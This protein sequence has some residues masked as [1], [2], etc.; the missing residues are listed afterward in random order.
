MNDFHLDLSD[1]TLI[2]NQI[3]SPMVASATVEECLAKATHPIIDVRSPGEF[4]EGH[5]PGAVNVPLYNDVE[6]KK[7]GTLYRHDGSEVATELGYSIAAEKFDSLVAK[8][9]QVLTSGRFS[10]DSNGEFVVHCWRGGLRSRGVAWLCK[11]NGLL[12]LVMEG[13]YKAYRRHSHSCLS[14][15]SNI[16]LLSGPTGVGKTR[17]LKT[18]AE[19]GE[20]VLDLEGL[21][22]HRGSVFGGFPG[23][24]QPTVEQ[25]QNNLFGRWQCLD[26]TKP[27]WIE[28]ESERIGRAVIP[29]PLFGQMRKAPMLYLN[30]ERSARVEFLLK[31]YGEFDVADLRLKAQ[32]IKKRL[33]G[34]RLKEALHAIDTANWEAFCELMIQ[35]YDKYYERSLEKISPELIERVDLRQPGEA[36]DINRLIWIGHRLTDDARRQRDLPSNESVE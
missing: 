25:F 22:C 32:R 27:V 33:G 20:E 19:H 7:I 28:G 30:A 23:V 14:I 6:R 15:S 21:A 31:D 10:E 18:L 3:S 4:E 8:V 29:E 36:H 9:R 24:K 26:S 35:Y 1:R 12:P 11:R 34:Q 2:V 17:L 13:G 16:I 5:L